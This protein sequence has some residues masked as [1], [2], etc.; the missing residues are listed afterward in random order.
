MTDLSEEPR[1]LEFDKVIRLHEEVVRMSGGMPGARD[2][3]LL[4][5]ALDRPQNLWFYA[6]ERAVA[7]LVALYAFGIAKNH[8]FLDGNKR[9]AALCASVFA[10]RCGFVFEPDID[11]AIEVYQNLAAGTLSEAEFADF[12]GAHLTRR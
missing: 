4:R 6:D 5:S 9:S 3:N 12:V 2:E 11:S 10:R 7:K 8:A 1:W